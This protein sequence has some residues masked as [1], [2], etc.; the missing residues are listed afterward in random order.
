LP[1]H[2]INP[3]RKQRT[4]AH[5]LA[6]L[7]ANHVEKFALHCGFA[8]VRLSQDYGLDLAIF[9]FDEDGFLEGGILWMQLKAT[10]YLRK[11]RDGSAVLIRLDRRDVLAWIAEANPIILVLYDAVHGC[12]YWLWIQDFVA[13]ENAFAKLHGKTITVSIPTAN[14]MSESAMREFARM[15]A[16]SRARQGDLQ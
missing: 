10:D 15:K 8:V 11:T 9:T 1:K 6:D 7:S 4:R 12:A 13:N 5:V 14:L 16:G 3:P 2:P